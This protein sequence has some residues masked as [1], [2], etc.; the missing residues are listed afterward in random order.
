MLRGANNQV[1]CK[2]HRTWKSLCRSLNTQQYGQI[3]LLLIKRKNIN[4]TD[5]H[6]LQESILHGPSSHSKHQSN[7]LSPTFWPIQLPLVYNRAAP[8]GYEQF[9]D[10]TVHCMH[11]SGTSLS[12]P[13]YKKAGTAPFCWQGRWHS[14]VPGLGLN[15]I[16]SHI[17]SHINT[18]DD[19]PTTRSIAEVLATEIL[20]CISCYAL[21][22]AI[23]A[24][25]KALSTS[26]EN[27]VE[28]RGIA[29]AIYH[30][31]ET[32]Q[33]QNCRKMQ[34][35][36]FTLSELVIWRIEV[37]SLIWKIID[38]AKDNSD[39]TNI[40]KKDR[41]IAVIQWTSK[42][43]I[44]DPASDLFHAIVFFESFKCLCYTLNSY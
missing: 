11:V 14:L 12:Q 25:S 39:C 32:A 20:F 30:R 38:T 18:F 33:P 44:R 27:T 31:I 1:F 23:H 34:G 42:K 43:K 8:K 22:C 36:A 5:F 3:L 35:V 37:S 6:R 19:T 24:C 4:Y 7:S 26:A 28:P 2:C 41:E 13:A 9:Q 15:P 16:I 29:P 40:R 21:H 17:L 10:P